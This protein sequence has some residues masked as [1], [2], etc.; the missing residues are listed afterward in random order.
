MHHISSHGM[1]VKMNGKP[2]CF[3]YNLGIIVVGHHVQNYN[4]TFCY[5]VIEHIGPTCK[6]ILLTVFVLTKALPSYFV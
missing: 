2:T 4:I 6:S 1:Y 3:T 5:S